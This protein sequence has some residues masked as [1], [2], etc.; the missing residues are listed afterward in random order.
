MST[1][2]P[3]I[4]EI[5]LRAQAAH[6]AIPGFNIPY[7]PMME[8]VARA[9]RDTRCFGLVMV[10]RLEWE[11]F[12]AGGVKPIY[13]TYQQ[14]K[15]ERFSR[16]H[17]DHVPVIDE[18]N[19]LVDY[20]AIL[21][22]AATLGYD[23]IMIDGSRL[24]LDDNIAATRRIVDMAH[25]RGVAVEAELGAVMG[26]ESG[27]MPPYE[28]LFAS[29]KGFTDPDEARRFVAETGVDWLSV[30]IGSV[31]GAISATARREKKLEARLSIERLDALR[32]TTGVPLVLHGGTGVKKECVLESVRHGIAKINIATAIRQPYEALM[33][34]DP[35]GALQAVYEATVAVV[36]DDLELMN[37]VDILNPG[38]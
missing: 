22:E 23:S 19:L 18:D 26:H 33:D 14:V 12:A 20:E 1:V 11:K 31:H 28:E 6:T 15:D 36:R 17:L 4:H 27:P 2:P 3:T 34:A 16:L 32:E 13:E 25:G 29:G 21:A 37:S 38:A 5:M 35:E 24:S 10:A 30:A 9:L 8:P 7:L